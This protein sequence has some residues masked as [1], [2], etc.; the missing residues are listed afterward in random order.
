MTDVGDASHP[1][2]R[3]SLPPV[4]PVG[5]AVVL[6]VAT[7]AAD[8]RTEHPKGASGLIV[9]TPVDPDHSYRIRMP[10]GDEISLRR[11]ELHVLKHFQREGIEHDPLA[12]YDMASC[13]VYRCVIGSR[14]Y[15]LDHSESDTDRRG[16]YLPAASQHWSIY[17][18]P[19]Q[20]EN[21]AT[22]ECYWEL[23]KFMKLA[24]KA[25]PN[26]LEVLY[27][28]L[29]EHIDPI[30]SPL[31]DRRDMFV[32]KLIYQTFNGYAMSQ[33]R[34]MEA[35]IRTNG[36]VKWKHAMHLLRL[37]L[38]GIVAM[39]EG[40]VPVLVGDHREELIAVRDGRMEWAEVDAWRKDLHQRFER[41][42]VGTR[43]PDRPDYEAANAILVRVRQAMAQREGL[44]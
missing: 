26:V 43:L 33:F 8:Q 22:Q 9:A 39:K 30:V 41:A 4:L 29:V 15:G 19:E 16:V 40:F 38:S 20:L 5:T 1:N 36:H 25:N 7:K 35:D 28:P 12:E 27:T 2:K 18:V 32:S 37:L 42:F 21:D 3:E 13:V 34:K 11:S 6:L 23:E 10:G 24:L 31:R 14:A 44:L 17:G